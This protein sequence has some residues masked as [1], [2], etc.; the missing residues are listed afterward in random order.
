M[1]IAFTGPRGVVL[2]AVAGLF[3]ERL[4]ALGFEDAALIGPLAFVLVAAT[5]VLHG[6]TLKPF[7]QFLGLTGAGNPGVLIIGGS[8]WTTALAEALVKVE[9]PV[10]MTDPNFGHLRAARA[11][12]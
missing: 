10:L 7:A 2:V 12:G 3:A 6:F 8:T 11:V 9:V 4:L 1:L 5:V